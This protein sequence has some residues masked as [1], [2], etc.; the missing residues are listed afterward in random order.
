MT[1]L[2]K[3]IL[4]QLKKG[5]FG[6]R[7]ADSTLSSKLNNKFK[8][9]VISFYFVDTHGRGN[10]YKPFTA[11]Q[12]IERIPK[13]IKYI[14]YSNGEYV[15]VI[16]D[17]NPTSGKKETTWDVYIINKKKTFPDISD[18]VFDENK[19]GQFNQSVIVTFKQYNE[20]LK[21]QNELAIAKKKKPVVSAIASA[22]KKKPEVVVQNVIKGTETIDVNNLGKGTADAK[23]FQ[24]L[25]WQY[26]NKY[27]TQKNLP[28]YTKFASYRTRGAD[29]GWDGK[30]G[31]ATKNYI[32][33]LYAGLK[34]NTYPELIKK[35]RSD[36]SQV[37]NE[38]TNYFKGIGINIK[39]KD[40]LREQ[41]LKEQ[42]GFDFSAANA[43][44]GSG[45]SGNISSTKKKP[46]SKNFTPDTLP[47]NYTG[48]AT[49]TWPSGTKYVGEFKDGKF[50][51]QGTYTWSSGE[52][53]VG[54]FKDGNNNGQG[55]FTYKN[56]KKH[57]GTWSNGKKTGELKIT[58]PNDDTR[59]GT[60]IN[61]RLTGSVTFTPK[62]GEP[63]EELWKDG[64]KIKTE[65]QQWEI[66]KAWVTAE[67]K[68]WEPGSNSTGPAGQKTPKTR[69]QMF[70]GM[71][72]TLDPDD[73]IGRDVYDAN[74]KRALE[75]LKSNLKSDIGQTWYAKVK[76]WIDRISDQIDDYFQNIETINITNDETG[77]SIYAT[78]E[79]E[80]FD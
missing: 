12:V 79:A 73:E 6:E 70:A 18:S 3:I 74:R 48:K 5:Q 68:W 40:I 42:D 38:S 8:Y 29:G 32:T 27:E 51:G 34:V 25:L 26:G 67:Q 71:N 10:K 77:D 55:T 44:I 39:L 56:G 23:A 22:E 78:V 46:S 57:E 11:D 14:T 64:V 47:A 63:V 75:W 17:Q 21:K 30:I 20:L 59:V 52:K 45:A 2:E 28:V 62:D 80:M 37:Q 24:E 15:F 61:D 58:Y 16:D 65:Q 4:E 36:L 19:S 60:A 53:Y 41:L 13:S 1:R 33:F 50:N 66:L 49:I 31:P 69:K 9:G 7:T 54:G 43:A 72:A 76:D 35:I